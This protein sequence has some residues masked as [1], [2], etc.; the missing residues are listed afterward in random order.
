LPIA[1]SHAEYLVI[2]SLDGKVSCDIATKLR[3]DF[4]VAGAAVFD[5]GLP[6]GIR[7]GRSASQG[8]WHP[9]IP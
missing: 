5:C 3:H 6:A 1:A 2:S 9:S 7:G 8:S 4:G